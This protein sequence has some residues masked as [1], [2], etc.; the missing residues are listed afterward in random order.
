MTRIDL[1]CDINALSNKKNIYLSKVLI[2]YTGQ[3]STSR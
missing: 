1:F 2:D 3:L